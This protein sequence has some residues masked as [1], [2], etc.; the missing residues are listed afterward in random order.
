MF[1]YSSRSFYHML[2][3][4]LFYTIL[5]GKIYILILVLHILYTIS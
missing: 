2:V 3:Y 4:L 1:F 5:Y